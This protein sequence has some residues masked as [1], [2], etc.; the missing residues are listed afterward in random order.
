MGRNCMCSFQSINDYTHGWA[1]APLLSFPEECA[2]N[3]TDRNATW[4]QKALS[5][6]AEKLEAKTSTG[7]GTQFG[8]NCGLDQEE[9]ADNRGALIMM[10][11]GTS[12]F[13]SSE[14]FANELP[15]LS[16][17]GT[18]ELSFLRTLETPD[19]QVGNWQLLMLK[20]SECTMQI[21]TENLD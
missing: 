4:S 6:P 11:R 17:Q 2:W 21:L 16:P 20:W 15:L 10:S 12:A 1:S 5:Q 9:T 7:L 18:G 14:G 8:I 13:W 3:S 19:S